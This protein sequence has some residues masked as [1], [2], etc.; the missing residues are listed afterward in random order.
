MQPEMQV[1][2]FDPA[3]AQR[4]DLGGTPPEMKPH[5]VKVAVPLRNALHEATYFGAGER[6]CRNQLTP[7]H[8]HTAAAG[9]KH[10]VSFVTDVTPM[11]GNDDGEMLRLAASIEAASA[12]PISEAVLEAARSRGITWNTGRDLRTIPG[13]G[14]E[15][16]VDGQRLFLG[17]PSAQITG[18]MKGHISK[19]QDDGKTVMVL[20]HAEEPL[21]L[22]AVSDEPRAEAREVVSALRGLGIRRLVVLTGITR[23]P[24]LWSRSP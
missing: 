21:G 8:A 15:A 9:S 13:S 5:R 22:L 4:D 6:V 3:E 20:T 24:P 16:T 17:K 23:R 10:R 19:L 11:G 18:E 14:I 12:H 1:I 2:E 7:A